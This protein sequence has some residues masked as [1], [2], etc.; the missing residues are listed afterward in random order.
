MTCQ[1]ECGRCLKMQTFDIEPTPY[2]LL[3]CN[4][5]QSDVKVR[6]GRRNALYN[7]ISNIELQLETLKL[8]IDSML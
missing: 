6:E 1:A 5:C 3:L 2:D 7:T 4:K 8:H